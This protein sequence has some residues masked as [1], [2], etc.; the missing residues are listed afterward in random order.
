MI[1]RDEIPG[2]AIIGGL[3]LSLPSLPLLITGVVSFDL[4]LT[5]LILGAVVIVLACL[6][7]VLTFRGDGEHL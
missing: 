5:L 4:F 7:M 1:Q 6:T 3:V 2:L